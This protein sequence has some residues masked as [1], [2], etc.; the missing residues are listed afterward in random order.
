MSRQTRERRLEAEER[1]P[2][3]HRLLVRY[4]GPTVFHEFETL[5]EARRAAV[6]G[7]DMESL[8]HAATEWWAW[9]Q[10][11]GWKQDLPYCLDAYG[12]ELDFGTDLEARKF[13]NQ[14]Y[15]DLIVAI[16][17]HDNGWKP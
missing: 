9:N 1:W 13:M 14:V 2:T 17:K 12:V 10:E 5:P 15:D 11:V 6:A 3:L 16:R 8:K 7:F 4:F